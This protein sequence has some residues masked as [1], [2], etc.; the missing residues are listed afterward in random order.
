[1]D[2]TFCPECGVSLPTPNEHLRTT[3][4]EAFLD[5]ATN[6]QLDVWL[7][8]L[9]KEPRG[10]MEDKRE[11]VRESTD[12]LTMPALEFPQ[13]TI[14]HLLAYAKRRDAAAFV[15]EELGIRPDVTWPRLIR[16]I[17][18]HVH[19]EEGWRAAEDPA[20]PTSV[21]LQAA[22]QLY[23]VLAKSTETDFC[24]EFA[25]EASEVWPGLV[26]SQFPI[27]T[28]GRV[29]KIDLHIG[30]PNKPGFG[31]EFKVPRT[32]SDVQRALGQLDQYLVGYPDGRLM[33]V[34]IDD[35]HLPE[36]ALYSFAEAVRA[37]GV[38]T[39]MKQRATQM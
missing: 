27:I 32:N 5:L 29:L 23:P 7:R 26:H 3:L 2:G 8:G 36:A 20:H 13:Q 10:R 17:L 28:H 1:M 19:V 37:R 30:L 16:R 22:A 11:R 21:A 12:Y 6:D 18:R 4:L 25:D 24:R 31:V 15:C 35:F 9:G 38:P 39:I 14:N 34:V 33:L